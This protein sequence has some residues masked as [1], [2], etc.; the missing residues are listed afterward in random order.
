M[1]HKATINITAMISLNLLRIPTISADSK[2]SRVR[3]AEANQ[4]PIFSFP[5]FLS[6]V[7]T[8]LNM[9][10]VFV[11]MHGEF[12]AEAPLLHRF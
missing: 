1:K 2:I 4:D 8:L 10:I 11:L 12:M 3:A 9:V 5:L 6:I 7:E